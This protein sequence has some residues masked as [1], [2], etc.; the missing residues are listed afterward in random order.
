VTSHE[1]SRCADWPLCGFLLVWE[2]GSSRNR[3]ERS[4]SG[5]AKEKALGVGLGGY[6]L[7]RFAAT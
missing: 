3:C 2:N 1:Q 6:G 5:P 4:D 7:F